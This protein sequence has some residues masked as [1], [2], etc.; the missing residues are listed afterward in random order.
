MVI[1]YSSD[2]CCK[3]WLSSKCVFQSFEFVALRIVVIEVVPNTVFLFDFVLEIRYIK[4]FR[5]KGLDFLTLT[6]S[7]LFLLSLLVVAV[8]VERLDS[9]IFICLLIFDGC[10]LVLNMLFGCYNKTSDIEMLPIVVRVQL[11]EF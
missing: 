10:V 7:V 3:V 8:V 11:I 4:S 6:V 1:Q 5:A 9:I 2:F